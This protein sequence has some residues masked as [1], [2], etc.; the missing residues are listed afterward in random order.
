ME[1]GFDTLPLKDAG[2][3]TLLKVF[4]VQLVSNFEVGEIVE[5]VTIR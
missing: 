2:A 1:Q 4:V 3:D 5:F